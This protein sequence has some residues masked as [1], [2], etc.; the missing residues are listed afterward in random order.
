MEQRIKH[1]EMIQSIVSR[2]GSNS[3]MLKGWAVSLVV[4]VFALPKG[5]ACKWV[6]LVI[7]IPVVMF[8]ILD[9]YY[10]TR[11]HAYRNL[12]DA[13]R[14]EPGSKTDFDLNAN[15]EEYLGDNTK[16]RRCVFSRTEWGFYVPLA[17]IALLV[18]AFVL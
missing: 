5:D 1:L 16:M 15:R 18:I 12:Y 3:F 13:V 17:I 14:L 9:S 10:L 8:W 11:E 2:M 6:Y 7:L 4:V